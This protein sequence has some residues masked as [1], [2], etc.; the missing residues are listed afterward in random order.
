M[1]KGDDG[2]LH[3]DYN[4]EEIKDIAGFY[5]PVPGGVGPVNVACIVENLVLAAEKQSNL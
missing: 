1:Y 4:E 2:K 5:T 3:G